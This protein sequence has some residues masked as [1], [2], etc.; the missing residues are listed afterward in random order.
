MRSS[1]PKRPGVTICG[2]KP[3]KATAKLRIAYR[4]TEIVVP[5]RTLLLNGAT[6][7][8]WQNYLNSG[9]RNCGERI[10]QC[11]TQRD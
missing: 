2:E 10:T 1:K 8:A 5:P 4:E 6:L 9:K 11:V 7:A 3:P